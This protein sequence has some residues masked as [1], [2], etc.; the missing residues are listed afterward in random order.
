[1]RCRKT[2][3]VQFG[4]FF[5]FSFLWLL[6]VS[7]KPS[8]SD[9][10]EPSWTVVGYLSVPDLHMW[11]SHVQFSRDAASFLTGCIARRRI[12]MEYSRCSLR[13]SWTLR[14]AGGARR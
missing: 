6:S 8:E 2:E 12:P 13:D 3:G 5:D 14:L 4:F 1:M 11:I 9:A 7:G 10:D